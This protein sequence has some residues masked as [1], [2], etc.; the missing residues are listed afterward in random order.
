MR[1]VDFEP[2]GG[3]EPPQIQPGELPGKL[4]ELPVKEL[5]PVQTVRHTHKIIKA[6]TQVKQGDYKPI[7]I[8]RNNRI[9]NGHHRYDALKNAGHHDARVYK[10]EQSIEELL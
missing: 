5:V 7:V 6:N 1:A 4:G 2:T 9:V 10:L 8:D 3:Q